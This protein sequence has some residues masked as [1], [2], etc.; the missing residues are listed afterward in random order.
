MLAAR[1][2][3]VMLNKGPY[4]TRGIAML[5]EALQRMQDHL[6]KKTPKMGPLRAWAHYFS[7]PEGGE[8]LL[9]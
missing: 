2:E 6:Y 5:A 3:C 7:P 9:P 1:T 4:L 8:A